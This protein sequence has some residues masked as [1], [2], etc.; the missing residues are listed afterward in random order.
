MRIGW[1]GLPPRCSEEWANKPMPKNNG[2][3]KPNLIREQEGDIFD[4]L[5]AF[6]LDGISLSNVHQAQ[7][8]ALV[9][10]QMFILG[11]THRLLR[12]VYDAAAAV[13][14]ENGDETVDTYLGSRARTAAL[15]AWDIFLGTYSEMLGRALRHAAAIPFGTLAVMH[16]DL[17]LPVV[18]V[19]E[20][21]QYRRVQFTEQERVSGGVFDPQ[22]QELVHAAQQRVEGD[23]LQLSNRIWR[24]D[25]ESRRGIDRVILQ[26]ID[27]GKSA[28]DTAVLLEQYLG[29][30]AT[31][32][33]WTEDRLYGLTKSDIRQGNRLGLMTGTNCNGQG[34]SYNALRLARTEIQAVHHMATD[35]IFKKMPWVEQEQIH[36]SPAHTGRD[37]CDDVVEGG[38]DGEGIYDKGEITLPLHPHCMCYKTAVQM[39][40]DAFVDKLRGWMTNTTQ[41]PAM[42]QYHTMIGGSI[43]TDLAKNGIALSMSYWAFSGHYTLNELFWTIALGS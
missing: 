5:A 38:E 32:P 20:Y 29:A 3:N 37:E 4:R 39:D 19:E 23:G 13:L 7:Q 8:V 11:E 31:C 25:Q 27:E 33:R 30:S 1:L 16:R 24:L 35:R 2:V 18:T 22:L 36:L 41:W 6:S 9:R 14:L 17:V 10:L 26:A 42:D 12:E 15:S 34:V 21:G 40:S 28:W 43:S